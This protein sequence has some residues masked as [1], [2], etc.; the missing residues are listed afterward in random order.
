ME[1]QWITGEKFSGNILETG[2]WSSFLTITSNSVLQFSSAGRHVTASFHCF[3]AIKVSMEI[4]F[5]IY[6]IELPWITG[7][8]FS[9]NIL[10]TGQWSSFLT[11][12]SNSVLQF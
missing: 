5:G 3:Y 11:I 9:G 10:E 8:T 2:Q 4:F 6:R 12:T 7:E 1:L